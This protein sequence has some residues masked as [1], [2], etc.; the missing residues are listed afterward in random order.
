MLFISHKI[1][2]TWML[3][4]CDHRISSFFPFFPSGLMCGYKTGIKLNRTR[5]QILWCS[6]PAPWADQL[7]LRYS[8]G[9]EINMNGTKSQPVYTTSSVVDGGS[10][11]M[12]R[13]PS[14]TQR[15]VPASASS[16]S[17]R[18]SRAWSAVTGLLQSAPNLHFKA[19]LSLHTRQLK[20]GFTVEVAKE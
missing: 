6:P 12:G 13:S 14:E 18:Y 19:F 8:P 11:T 9:L 20:T 10:N 3:R 2:G 17:S 16:P 1:I 7:L 15:A 5:I 4:I